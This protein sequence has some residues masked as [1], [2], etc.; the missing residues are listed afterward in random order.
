MFLYTKLILIPNFRLSYETQ[1]ISYPPYHEKY[2]IIIASHYPRINN[3]KKQLSKIVYGQSKYI[4]S[5]FIYWIDNKVKKPSL[6]SLVNKNHLKTNVEILDSPNKM[7]TDRFIVPK[8]LKTETI[9]SSDD[10][11]NYD[12]TDIDKAFEI[13]I[14]NHFQNRICGTIARSFYDN[15]YSL[16]IVDSHYNLIL[17]GL[18]FLNRRMLNLYHDSNYTKLRSFVDKQM[19]GEDILM[20]YIVS[21]NYK[22][23]PVLLNFPQFEMPPSGLSSRP[24][25]LSQR[26]ESCIF[27]NSFFGYNVLSTYSTYGSQPYDHCLANITIE[28]FA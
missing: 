4:D 17:T 20:N 25:H 23:S 15:M 27:F 11:L 28:Y 7:I 26:T 18:A 3:L 22:T 14:S 2:S 13:Y 6:E 9:L 16:C 24:A 5:V 8:H 1:I 12:A 19:N 10:D 21:H